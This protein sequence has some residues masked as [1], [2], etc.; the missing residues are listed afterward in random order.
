MPFEGVSVGGGMSLGGGISVG[1]L[2]AHVVADISGLTTG[3]GKGIKSLKGFS[4]RMDD[5]LKRNA[6]A[7][8][9]IGMRAAIV[10]GAVVA[11]VGGMVKSYGEFERRMRRA[12]AVSDY[13]E[14]EFTEMSRMAE[15]ASVRL[16]IAATQAADAFYFL[17][18]AGLT[19]Q[20]QMAAF[21]G[22]LDFAKAGVM[23]VGHAAEI[24]VDVIKGTKST[25][26]ETT[27]ATDILTEAFTSANLTLSHLGESVSL[28][29]SIAADSHTPLNEV[30]AAFGL[31]ANAGIKGSRAGTALRRAFVNLM[32]PSKEMSG[33]LR[34]LGVEVYD[35][36]GRMKPLVDIIVEMSKALEGAGE[37]QRKHA[38]ITIFG[39]R[40][41]TGMQAVFALG[42]EGLRAYVEQLGN[43]EG[44]TERVVQKQMKAFME[45]IERVGKLAKLLARHIGM[46]LAPAIKEF[47]D[48][49]RPVIQR[50]VEWVD[51]NR[52][53]TIALTA[54]AAAMGVVALAAGTLMLS[55][56]GLSITAIALK[57]S[58]VSLGATVAITT[59]G[60]GALVSAVVYAVVKMKR[61]R[62]EMKLLR[63]EMDLAGEVTKLTEYI[64]KLSAMVTGPGPM[65][66]LTGRMMGIKGGLEEINAKIVEILTATKEELIEILEDAGVKLNLLQRKVLITPFLREQAL[67]LAEST[68]D[69]IIEMARDAEREADGM[70]RKTTTKGGEEVVK[71]LSIYEAAA[72][73]RENLRAAEYDNWLKSTER[74]TGKWTEMEFRRIQATREAMD[75]MQDAGASF[76]EEMIVDARNWRDHVV[77]F[78]KDVQ[79]ALARAF[80]ATVAEQMMKSTIAQAISGALLGVAIGPRVPIKTAEPASLQR[81][82]IVRRP[83][84]ARVGEVPEAFVPLSGGRSIPVEI[85]GAGSGQSTVVTIHNEG[86]ER[87][88]I[89]RA[90]SYVLSDQRIIDVFLRRIQTDRPLRRGISQIR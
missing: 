90:E 76:F 8:R 68:R 5:F 16:N 23:E 26:E 25:F 37:E 28:V 60:I 27:T 7:M 38:L 65:N 89:G 71:R 40:A 77:N 18:S 80:A 67:K 86:R 2:V 4:A 72:K 69:T 33:V 64:T 66:Q 87:L 78:I 22:V 44:A 12:A 59:L 84:I 17:G 19:I 57:V 32:D 14:E 39:V 55:L 74:A 54:T 9:R 82:G 21:P 49:L 46:S 73:E 88:E 61:F 30:A 45:Q 79:R 85:S 56:A 75:D 10:G 34:S 50:M 15:A 42:T 53:A 31:M 20:E 6:N 43:A 1:T 41:I 24:L 36:S 48:W 83:T 47:G 70:M 52:D 62:A 3:I 13:T 81:G 35:T 63:E 29:A 51:A 11:A 58:V